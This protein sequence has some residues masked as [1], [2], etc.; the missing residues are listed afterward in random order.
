MKNF[1]RHSRLS[2]NVNAHG[3]LKTPGLAFIYIL[4]VVFLF[5]S[6]IANAQRNF[7]FANNS[8]SSLTGQSKFQAYTKY[9]DGKDYTSDH[10]AP[11]TSVASGNW[12]NGATW[13]TGTVPGAGDDV[14]IAAGHTVTVDAAATSGNLTING[15]LDINNNINL[16]VYGDFKNDG[17]FNAGTGT[18]SVT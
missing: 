4:S 12:S 3:N 10:F 17:T 1:L 18:S 9:F 15:E 14:T 13:S 5:A 7:L 2:E 16:D 6:S 8:S 11:V